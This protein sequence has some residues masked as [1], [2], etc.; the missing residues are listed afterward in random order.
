MAV[1]ADGDYVEM[2]FK[3]WVDPKD[4]HAVQLT[5]NDS[6]LPPDGARAKFNVNPKS[7]DYNPSLRDRLGV[8]LTKHGKTAP[9]GEAQ[10]EPAPPRRLDKRGWKWMG[11]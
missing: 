9:A 8:V 5:S 4:P 3:V 11:D 1:P 6:D 7:A 2:L 10:E